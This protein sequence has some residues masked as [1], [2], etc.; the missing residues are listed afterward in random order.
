MEFLFIGSQPCSAYIV[1][2]SNLITAESNVFGRVYPS[3]CDCDAMCMAKERHRVI[4]LHSPLILFPS[5]SSF[6]SIPYNIALWF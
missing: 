2:T 6:P 3:F 5:I 4:A 1:L